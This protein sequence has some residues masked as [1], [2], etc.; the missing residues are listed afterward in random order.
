L[1]NVTNLNADLLLGFLDDSDRETRNKIAWILGELQTPKAIDSLY[2]LLR[3]DKYQ[4][5][6]EKAAIALGKIGG[7]KVLDL[8]K[9]ALKEDDWFIRKCA[10]SAL[11]YSKGDRCFSRT[12]SRR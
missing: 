7:G 8:L 5:V 9:E 3:E 2:Y 4:E 1:I 12:G 6:K 11:G 10:T